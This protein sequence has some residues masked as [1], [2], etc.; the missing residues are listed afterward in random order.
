MT[1]LTVL[2]DTLDSVRGKKFLVIDRNLATQVS[3]LCPFSILTEHGVD[4]IF[5]LQQHEHG[6]LPSH[7]S[8]VLNSAKLVYLVASYDWASCET[9]VAHQ[10]EIGRSNTVESHAVLVPDSLS[11]KRL[12]EKSQIHG[13]TLHT[14]DV[15]SVALDTDMYT[16]ALGPS[17][18]APLNVPDK[19]ARTTPDYLLVELAARSLHSL[20]QQMGFAG[21]IL[22]RG[23]PNSN[24]QQLV[25]LLQK[26]KDASEVEAANSQSRE[27]QFKYQH[28]SLL[29]GEKIEQIIIIDRND[30]PLTPLLSQL[31]YSGLIDEFWGLNENGKVEIEELVPTGSNA[32]SSTSVPSS[33]M[34]LN[35][36]LYR[37]VRDLNF[38][39]VGARLNAT[40]T[41]LQSDYGERHKAKTVTEIKSFVGK[42]SGLTDLHTHLKLHTHL[43]ELIMKRLQKP[44]FNRILEVQQNLVADTMDISTLHTMM[45]DLIGGT[46]PLDSILR[47]LAI[48]SLVNGGIKEKQLLALRREVCQTYGHQH[49][50]TFQNLEKMGL[51]VPKQVS[52]Y[53]SASKSA[54]YPLSPFSRA[55]PV[56]AKNLRVISE[57]Q[58]EVDETEIGSAYSGYSPISIRLVQCVIDKEAVVP[59]KTSK[60]QLQQFNDHGGWKGTEDL[61]GKDVP[62]I[63]YYYTPTV[64]SAKEDN[65]RKVKQFLSRGPRKTVVFFLGGITWAEVSALRLLAKSVSRELIVVTTGVIN[66]SAMVKP[67]Y[68]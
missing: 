39:S 65:E 37:D 23:G 30:D 9:V 59:S 47:L 34:F 61:L 4:K 68:S 21:R 1:S 41:A 6:Q 25:K 13:L 35:D 52:G 36:M 26:H 48:E 56:L 57:Q 32:S 38:S 53:F 55:F 50:V 18:N 43:S 51:V 64:G 46:A 15:S 16:L 27:Q 62:L 11:F 45:E 63:D 7:D 3:L 29:I 2:L 12:L 20:Q 24:T 40:A 17:Q 33:Q 60:A 67:S 54:E 5:W 44:E 49:F 19:R 31:T 58:Q 42:L 10:K 22:G 8:I 66:G 14:W 28:D